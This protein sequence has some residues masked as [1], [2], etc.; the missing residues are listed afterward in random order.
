M[1]C[2]VIVIG[3]MPTEEPDARREEAETNQAPVPRIPVVNI[4]LGIFSAPVY[5]HFCDSCGAP[6]ETLHV[7]REANSIKVTVRKCACKRREDHEEQEF[8]LDGI[9]I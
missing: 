4:P 2:G 5:R 1:D 8:Y 7:E 9:T 6:L 3:G